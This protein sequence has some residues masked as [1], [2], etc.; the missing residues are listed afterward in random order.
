MILKRR[1]CDIIS[2]GRWSRGT[3]RFEHITPSFVVRTRYRDRNNYYTQYHNNG[4]ALCAVD[5]QWYNVGG[6][7]CTVMYDLPVRV[8]I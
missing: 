8:F 6:I 3:D 7:W 2:V 1:A 4:G 5:T